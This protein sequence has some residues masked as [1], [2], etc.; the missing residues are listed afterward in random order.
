MISYNGIRYKNKVPHLIFI[1]SYEQEVEI[2]I[3][4]L[5]AERVISNLNK[6]I[7]SHNK[8][9]KRENEEEEYEISK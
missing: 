7:V 5:T 4:N 9:V 1:N 6:I 3:D 2:P 8:E